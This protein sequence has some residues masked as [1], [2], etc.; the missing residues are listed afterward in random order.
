MSKFAAGTTVSVEQTKME[1]ERC[2]TRYK[3]TGFMSGWDRDQAF[4]GFVIAERQVRIKMSL[5]SRDDKTFHEY[6]WGS[7]TFIRQESA[8]I[9]LWEQACRQKWRALALLIKAKL[10]AV[11][12]EIEVLEDVFLANIVLPDGQVVGDAIKESLRLAYQTGEMQ[13]LLPDYSRDR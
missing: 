3:A 13:R 9:A 4:I 1:I 10:E 11:D 8:A 2:L 6:M 7:S 12:A 5:P